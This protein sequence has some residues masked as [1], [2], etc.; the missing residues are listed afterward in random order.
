M[1][2]FGFLG[3]QRRIGDEE[4][5]RKME[6][7][8]GRKERKEER[9][10]YERRETEEAEGREHCLEMAMKQRCKVG[11]TVLFQVSVNLGLPRWCYW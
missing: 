11:E 9:E 7:K 1:D 6:E 5:Q 8:R 2:G 4:R 3:E 10:G